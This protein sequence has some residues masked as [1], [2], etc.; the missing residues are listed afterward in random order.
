MNPHRSDLL[1]VVDAVQQRLRSGRHPHFCAFVVQ[2]D[3]RA[4]GGNVVT[5]RV[6]RKEWLA[7]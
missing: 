5:E 3:D 7:A 4:I 2:F 1:W 6:L